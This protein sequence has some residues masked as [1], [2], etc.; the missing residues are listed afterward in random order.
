[1]ESLTENRSLLY[2]LAGAGGFVVMLALGEYEYISVSSTLY[3][4]PVL[5][6]FSGWLPEFSE[7][8]SVVD[9]PAEYRSILVQVLAVDAA[10]AFLIDRILLY[11]AGEGSLNIRM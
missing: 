2:S 10:A 5:S 7:Q 1:M 9:F 4:Y 8:F 3:L 11:I 6:P